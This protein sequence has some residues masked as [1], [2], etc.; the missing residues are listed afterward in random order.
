MGLEIYTKDLPGV[1]KL[2]NKYITGGGRNRNFIKHMK[3]QTGVAFIHIQEK[4]SEKNKTNSK[5]ESH[6]FQYGK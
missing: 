6:F 2:L 1:M 3:D 4:Y 5:G